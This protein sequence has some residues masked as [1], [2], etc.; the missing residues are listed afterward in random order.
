[1]SAQGFKQG[2]HKKIYLNSCCPWM[3]LAKKWMQ[4]TSNS[5]SLMHRKT[6]HLKMIN[7]RLKENTWFKV[8]QI[9]TKLSKM[10]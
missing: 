8:K 4:Q 7:S 5:L 9:H 10:T 2:T 1:M 3:E 6:L